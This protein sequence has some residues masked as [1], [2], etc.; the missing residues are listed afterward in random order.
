MAAGTL[1]RGGVAGGAAG[2]AAWVVAA[3][4][5]AVAAMVVSWIMGGKADVGMTANGLL[6]GLFQLGSGTRERAFFDALVDSLGDPIVVTDTRGRAVYANS[7]YLKLAS[8]AGKGRLTEGQEKMR[9]RLLHLGF[10]WHECRHEVEV[11][12][13]LRSEGVDLKGRVTV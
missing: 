13:A 8:K 12:D 2:T 7:G 3:A 10:G 11:V 1:G 9:D 5:G 4:A 6:A